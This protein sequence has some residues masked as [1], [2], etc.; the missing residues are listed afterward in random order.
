MSTLC[1]TVTLKLTS[2]GR[3][4]VEA[5]FFPYQPVCGWQVE[6]KKPGDA[7]LTAMSKSKDKTVGRAPTPPLAR[8][9]TATPSL[10]SEP[11]DAF[12]CSAK[13][14]AAMYGISILAPSDRKKLRKVYLGQA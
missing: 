13:D 8:V 9:T 3:V 7:F 11:S 2:V 1:T 5:N 4:C 10:V 6:T 12:T 14:D